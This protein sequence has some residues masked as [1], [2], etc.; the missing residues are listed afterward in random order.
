MKF[1][2]KILQ[3]MK[4]E[5]QTFR[6]VY[7]HAFSF[8]KE[9]AFEWSRHLII[10]KTTYEESRT[11]ILRIA[12]VLKERT[13]PGGIIAICMQNSPFWV[14][15]FWAVLMAG[16]TVQPVSCDMP[17]DLV[18]CCMKHTGAGYLIGGI[19][20]DSFTTFAEN[21]L[22]EAVPAKPLTSEPA[23]GWGDEVILS[24]S[25]TTG[26][27]KLFSY[28]GKEICAQILNSEYV[29]QNSREISRF[30]HGQFRQLAFLPFSHIF[31]LTACYLWFAVFGRTFVF[32][33]DYAPSTILRTCRLHHVT[34]IFA[35]PLLWDSLAEGILKEAAQTGQSE[36]LERAVGLALRLQNAVPALSRFL[37][38]LMFRQVAE[39]TLGSSVQ[40]CISGGGACRR[41]TMRI[42]NGC[43]YHLE[44]GY[45][46]TEIGI[47]SVTLEKKAGSRDGSSVGKPF[48]SLRYRIGD[49]DRLNVLGDTCY[50]AE[51]IDGKRIPRDTD[52]WFDTGDCVRLREDGHIVVIGRSDDLFSD[53]DGRR[54]SPDMIETL[55]NLPFRSCVV[56]DAS[57]GVILL[58]EV[59]EQAK[60]SLSKRQTICRQ[61][62]EALENIPLSMRPRTVLY[63]YDPIP[64]SLSYKFRR[65]KIVESIGS[66][67]IAA[68]SKKDFLRETEDG[69]SDPDTERT[70]SEIAGIMKSVLGDGAEVLPQSDFFADLGGDSL[71]YIEFLNAVERRYGVEI[72]KEA[73]G[74]CTTPLSAY[75]VISEVAEL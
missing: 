50:A 22:L 60:L 64:V 29:L 2:E 32:L 49:G 68:L 8:G 20:G 13:V 6:T 67:A 69:S 73:T 35:I 44:N 52:A 53:A 74:R 28:T 72:P 62:G 25:A 40:F 48:P 45:G 34:H 59:P 9:V 15:C 10:R 11:E 3:Q 56:H 70:V 23:D 21:E 63:T 24:T 26:D 38:P 47:A 65:K 42:V 16:C 1:Y 46:M 37:V 30:W 18:R 58:A 51:F 19:E 41:D 71:S 36:K 31:G 55:L 43:G 7:D 27:P 57:A 17:A 5:P 12:G 75:S 54:I 39:K 4:S 14:E 61:V 33:E 66:G